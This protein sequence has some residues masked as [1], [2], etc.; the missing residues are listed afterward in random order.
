MAVPQVTH[1]NPGSQFVFRYERLPYAVSG[2]RIDARSAQND[3]IKVGKVDCLAIDTCVDDRQQ[4]SVSDTFD[5]IISTNG[6]TGLGMP[7]GGQAIVNNME[8]NNGAIGAY[9]NG[10]GVTLNNFAP[11]PSLTLPPDGSALLILAGA[12]GGNITC[13]QCAWAHNSHE[14]PDGTFISSGPSTLGHLAFNLNELRLSDSSGGSPPS[15]TM[16]PTIHVWLGGT[17][18]INT[19]GR[20]IYTPSSPAHY[21]NY[22]ETNTGGQQSY[23]EIDLYNDGGAQSEAW[24]THVRNVLRASQVFNPYRFD[25]GFMQQASEINVPA[26]GTIQPNV[27][28]CSHGAGA[29]GTD[30][31]YMAVGSVN[32]HVNA[33]GAASAKTICSQPVPASCTAANTPWPCCTGAGVGAGCVAGA[34]GLDN[35]ANFVK[36]Q[37]VPPIGVDTVQLYAAQCAEPC[38]APAAGSFGLIETLNVNRSDVPPQINSTCTGAGT[39]SSCCTGVG[40]GTCNNS[41]SNVGF[42]DIGQAR[43]AAPPTGA[44]TTGQ[45]NAALFGASKLASAPSIAPGAGK[46]QMFAVAGTNAGTC[47]IVA[48]CGTSATTFAILDNIGGG[49]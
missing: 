35:I 34:L 44:D 15:A 33:V 16:N 4:Q 24:P 43:G 9:I 38:A 29:Q 12:N 42:T 31:Y 22:V 18:Q 25:T 39:P 14:P 40:L 23:R 17:G 6:G 21:L 2:V 28:T 36:V 30:Y 10:G 20:Y 1:N 49:C 19:I 37:V 45:V 41:P 3:V 11:Q 32:G 5:E 8:V 13:N 27:G 48:T 46:C 26:I 47:K 7:R